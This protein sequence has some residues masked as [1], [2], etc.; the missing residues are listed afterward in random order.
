MTMHACVP[1][2]LFFSWQVKT[3]GQSMII[4]PIFNLCTRYPLQLGRQIQCGMRSLPDF[5]HMTPTVNRTPDRLI[6]SSTCLPLGRMS[7]VSVKQLSPSISSTKI[8]CNNAIN[9][10]TK[11]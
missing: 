5:V 4:Y 3:R 8:C 7:E 2:A 11:S 9:A 10:P 1:Q 6:L